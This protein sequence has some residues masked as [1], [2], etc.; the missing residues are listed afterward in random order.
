VIY[1]IK[2]KL[3]LYICPL[4]TVCRSDDCY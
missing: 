3:P 2:Y 1:E 4:T